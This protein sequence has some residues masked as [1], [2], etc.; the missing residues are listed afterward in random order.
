MTGDTGG[1]DYRWNIANC[2]TTIDGVG[3]TAGPGAGQHGR[4]DGQGMDE[5]IARDPGAYWDD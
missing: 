5:L 3:D 2:N 4:P 1:D